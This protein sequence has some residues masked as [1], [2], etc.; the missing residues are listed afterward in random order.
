MISISSEVEPQVLDYQTQQYKVLPALATAYAFQFVSK[1]IKQLFND[2][3]KEIL[4]NKF[5]RLPE[6]RILL[7]SFPYKVKGT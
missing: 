6:V 7:S 4:Q 1:Y 5:G 3:E 2:I